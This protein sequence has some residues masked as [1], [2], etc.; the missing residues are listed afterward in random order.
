MASGG[1]DAPGYGDHGQIFPL[2]GSAAAW[3]LDA[4]C[5]LERQLTSPPLIL[6]QH[7]LNSE[8]NWSAAPFRFL[9]ATLQ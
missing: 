2:P 5:M 4:S 1:M 3:K 6:V 9:T 7:P 8:V